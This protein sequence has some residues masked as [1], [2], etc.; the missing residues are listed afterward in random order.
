MVRAD[1]LIRVSVPLKFEGVAP[2]VKT[3]AGV[4]VKVM[5]DLEVEALP[6][7]LPHELIVDVTKIE[8][9]EDQVLVGDIKMPTGVKAVASADEVVALVSVMKEEVEELAEPVDLTKIEVE[10]KGKKPEEGEEATAA[11]PAKG[12]PAAPAAKK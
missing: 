8:K 3:F 1:E 2:A 9:L 10:K 11:A 5:H 6:A 4:L 7:N 12:G